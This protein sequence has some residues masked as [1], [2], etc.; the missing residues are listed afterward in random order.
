MTSAGW[1]K[2]MS[3]WRNP[4]EYWTHKGFD[5]TEMG[6][7]SVVQLTSGILN[8]S[9]RHWTPR[10]IA[11]RLR[12]M[13]EQ[14]RHPDSPWLTSSMVSI[15]ET[16]L[17]PTDF[18]VEWGS[19]RSTV[20]FA[21]RTRKLMSVEHNPDWQN[22]VRKTLAREGL[23][24]R[25][26]LRLYGD[27]RSCGAR[28]DYVSAID[29]IADESLGYCLVDGFTQCRDQC[30]LRALPKLKPGAPIIIGT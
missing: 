14:R 21:R 3:Y 2:P 9:F 13:V 5:H 11:D 18:G 29:D 4:H 16:W 8:R 24:S 15:L 25:V 26:D 7:T 19:G 30:A 6:L 12:L 23:S 1:I 28:S 20:W 10:Y 17:K 27:V 22:H